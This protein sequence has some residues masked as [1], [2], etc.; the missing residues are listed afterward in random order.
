MKV[1]T[2]GKPEASIAKDLKPCW[3]SCA[4]HVGVAMDNAVRSQR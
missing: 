4:R 3:C 2:V 1:I